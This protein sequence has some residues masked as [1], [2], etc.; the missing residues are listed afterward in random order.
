MPTSNLK[1]KAQSLMN[2]AQNLP[3]QA[4]AKS[5][6]Q[7]KSRRA[8]KLMNRAKRQI[9]GKNYQVNYPVGFNKTTNFDS[10]DL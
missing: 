6:G 4:P 5:T 1:D 9:L 2:K 10:H 7:G 8:L 3:K